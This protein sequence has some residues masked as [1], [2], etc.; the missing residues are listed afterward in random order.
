MSDSGSIFVVL[1]LL[2]FFL[3]FLC[4]SYVY[5]KVKLSPFFN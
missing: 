5:Y 2:Y 1:D 4:Y 3:A